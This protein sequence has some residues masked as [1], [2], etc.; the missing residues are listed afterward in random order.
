VVEDRRLDPAGEER[1]RLTRE[2]LVERVVRR[3]EDRQP[4]LAPA[5]TTPLLPER[6]DRPREADGDRA[7]EEADVDSQLECVCCGDPEQLAVDE[8]PLDLA[9]LLGRVARPVGGEPRSGGR[10]DSLG[11]EPV[12]ELRGLPAL[13][14][15]DRP[16]PT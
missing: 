9:A 12:D 15:A 3:D 14:E 6:R 1:L 4:A 13:R 8:T 11:R 16:Q 2:E 5:G 7:V 10:V